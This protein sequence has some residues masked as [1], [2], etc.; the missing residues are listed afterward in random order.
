MKS[1]SNAQKTASEIAQEIFKVTKVESSFDKEGRFLHLIAKLGKKEF[2][3]LYSPATTVTIFI[4]GF[5]LQ[6]MLNGKNMCVLN[7]GDNVFFNL[8]IIENDYHMNK[9]KISYQNKTLGLFTSKKLLIS[10]KPCTTD[11]YFFIAKSVVKIL[12]K[13][14]NRNYVN[15]LNSYKYPVIQI[16]PNH[17]EEIEFDPNLVNIQ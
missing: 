9:L 8:E 6:L 3:K 11:E 10:S 7:R 16:I 13:F 1:N 2:I 17:L 5:W 14:R 4:Q 15:E 12:Q